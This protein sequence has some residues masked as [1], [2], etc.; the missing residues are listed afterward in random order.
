M[1]MMTAVTSVVQSSYSLLFLLLLLLFVVV[2]VVVVVA[3]VVVWCCLSKFSIMLPRHSETVQHKNHIFHPP[4]TSS[5]LAA[6][7]HF[8]RGKSL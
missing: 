3:V 6:S 1:A 8:Q 2:V 5:L 4:I 7:L